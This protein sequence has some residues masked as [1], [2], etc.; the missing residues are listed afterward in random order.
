M[1]ATFLGPKAHSFQQILPPLAFPGWVLLA[2]APGHFLVFLRMIFR[3][4]ISQEASLDSPCT[5]H[6]FIINSAKKGRLG[7]SVC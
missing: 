3:G 7:G 5:H 1:P 4:Y 6:V 2:G